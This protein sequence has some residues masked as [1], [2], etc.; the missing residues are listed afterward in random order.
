MNKDREMVLP[1]SRLP[2][3]MLCL[4]LLHFSTEKI[5]ISGNL[6][7]WTNSDDC[8]TRS[9]IESCYLRQAERRWVAT[10]QQMSSLLER[11]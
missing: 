5:C 3:L 11:A 8:P 9:K 4:A 10:N 1:R 2:S 6:Q 7:F